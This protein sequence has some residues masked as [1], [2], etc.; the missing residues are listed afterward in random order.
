MTRARALA[1]A[2][3]LGFALAA[4]GLGASCLVDNKTGDFE[5][6][7][8]ADCSD[9]RRCEGGYCILDDDLPP[10]GPDEPDG[11][12]CPAP[13]TTC[14]FTEM[15]CDIDCD[16][17]QD[18]DDVV[19]PAGFAC[20]VDCTVPNACDN[21]DCSQATSCDIRC[22]GSSA[23]ADVTCGP[24]TCTVVCSGNSACDVVDCAASCACDVDC[25]GGL[26]CDLAS[27]PTTGADCT[28]GTAA[29]C[30]SKNL[31]CSTCQ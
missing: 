16:S 29:G 3:A 22:T 28:D 6:A 2:T 7:S 27:C 24:G 25:D 26:D 19:C 15:T 10:D 12:P 30:D 14:S 1:A 9:G 8:Q 17:S 4:S 13:C 18:C 21:V 31:G 5:C 23:C 20:D 11:M